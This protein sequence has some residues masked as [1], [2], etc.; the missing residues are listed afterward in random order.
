MHVRRYPN[1]SVYKV[2]SHDPAK[3]K[4]CAKR[5]KRKWKRRDSQTEIREQ[6]SE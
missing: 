1:I 3:V 5:L 4:K 2:E 6:R